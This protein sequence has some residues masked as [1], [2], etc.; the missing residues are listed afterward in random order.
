[1]RS[2]KKRL[3]GSL[4]YALIDKGTVK[5]PAAVLAK[6]LARSG[7]D[8]IQLR[9]K[10]SVGTKILR[11]AAAISKA[12]KKTGCLFIVNDFPDI[13]KAAGSDGVHIGQSDL[14]IE[15]ARNIVGQG[16]LVGVSCSNLKQALKAQELGADYIGIGPVFRT[17][18]KQGCKPIGLKKI[19]ELSKRVKIPVFA[20]G[21]INRENLPGI[22][23]CGIRRVAVCRA[24]L[25]SGNI[26]KSVE[27]F[28][29]ELRK[30]K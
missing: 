6:K 14:T 20:I 16:R 9:D 22:I 4:L 11:E 17:R 10:H 21:N 15:E 27:Y 5:G 1:M 8:I 28:S 18:T 26:Q 30:I 24:I 25:K 3:C 12:L 13:A 7:V 19:Q 23:S 2:R 29:R